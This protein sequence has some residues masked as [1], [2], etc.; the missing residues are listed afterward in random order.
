MIC[1]ARLASGTGFRLIVAAHSLRFY[2]YSR[3]AKLA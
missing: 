2:P 1:L 3:P